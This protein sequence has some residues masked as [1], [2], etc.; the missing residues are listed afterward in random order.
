MS[1]GGRAVGWVWGA[2]GAVAGS[3]V[4]HAMEVE[5]WPLWATGAVALAVSAVISMVVNRGG[6][7][8][9]LAGGRTVVR[10]AMAVGIGMAAALGW[11]GLWYSVVE[12]SPQRDSG[13]YEMARGGAETAVVV[14]RVVRVAEPRRRGWVL[15]IEPSAFDDESVRAHGWAVRVFWPRA[16]G[17]PGGDRESGGAV[18]S[19]WPPLPGDRIEAFI[20]MDGYPEAAFP[21]GMDAR[22]R[23]ARRGVAGRGIID[24]ELQVRAPEGGRWWGWAPRRVSA[25]WRTT[26]VMR[27][28]ARLGVETA[29]YP[30]AMVLGARGFLEDEQRRPFEATGTAHLMAISGLH[31]GVLAVGIWWFLGG[32][33]NRVP[34]LLR[35]WGR[36][37]SC[38]FG[39]VM[40]IGLY[41]VGIG[42]PTSAVRAWWMLTCG[43]VALVG[44]RSMASFRMLAGAVYAMLAF[45]PL[46]AGDVGFQL[47][48][49]ATAAILLW[50]ERPPAW[51]GELFASSPDGKLTVGER[52]ERWGRRAA[53]GV[54]VSVVATLV[55]WPLI[56]AMTG[57]LP[58][59]GVVAN[60]VVTPL[61]SATLIPWMFAGMVTTWVWEAPGW[62]MLAVGADGMTW[63][64]MVLDGVSAAPLATWVVGVPGGGWTLV[65]VVGAMVVA[66]GRARRR[67]SL[68][69]GVL[70]VVSIGATPGWRAAS[71]GLGWRG[72]EMHAIPVGQGDST[73]VVT[74][75]GESVLVDGGGRR[76][77]RDPG[78]AIVVPYLKRLGIGALDRVVVTHA[79]TD[80]I[81]GLRAVVEEM[82]P[83]VA[84]V[85]G[86]DGS[87]N[88]RE[89]LAFARDEGVEVR[90]VTD[91]WRDAAGDV[92][93][94]IVA[95]APLGASTNDR[96]LYIDLEYAGRRLVMP[97]DI[98]A[99]AERWLAKRG[100]LRAAEVMKVPHHG[101]KTSSTAALLEAVEPTAAIV[102]AGPDNP[103]GHP[104]ARV[105]RRYAAH[106]VTL[107]ET[108]EAGLIVVEITPAGRVTVRPH[109]SR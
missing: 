95:P 22:R 53:L 2:V 30:A 91:V 11:A 92:E 14:G 64:G 97:G 71:D 99:R 54:G 15:Q 76:F 6:L 31:L 28:V 73:L 106:G 89:W 43:V 32:C 13:L 10:R 48:V 84:V 88:L 24:G 40:V 27:M 78:R 4:G 29:A 45:D 80:H 108:A 55:T 70:L 79:D 72:L 77:G 56:V 18:M 103:F 60:V 44:L 67:A 9:Q 81:G 33:V 52:V 37:R 16:P 21:H 46:A 61:A 19:A 66:A 93:W 3:L 57:E 51:A 34:W 1:D 41:V 109:R 105:V 58:T 82:R 63:L 38:G 20:R 90:S 62:W 49:G 42:A 39:V 83:S 107:F 102:S 65:G 85:D 94:R 75:T 17:G 104:H 87:V 35:R 7:G 23:M 96:S 68:V 86:R 25:A 100:H 8:G 69:G 47:S 26:T 50:V 5:S 36:R 98:E 12:E 101:S 59:A 74:P